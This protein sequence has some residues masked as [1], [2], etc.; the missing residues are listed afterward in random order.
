MNDVCDFCNDEGAVSR[1]G[2][3][4]PF[5]SREC[6]CCC[7]MGTP[8][9]LKRLNDRDDLR[10]T[11]YNAD[12]CQFNVLEQI[13]REK[14]REE[15]LPTA[16]VNGGHSKLQLLL[17]R[18]LAQTLMSC[19]MVGVRLTE[20]EICTERDYRVAA[21]VIQWLGTNIGQ[22]FINECMDEYRR[23]VGKEDT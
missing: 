16:G 17:S 10:T 23:R 9:K 5:E 12:R 15:T 8:E 6:E 11:G 1:P 19:S 21:T 22:C 7:K 13:F 18:R 3:G 2:Q 4:K 14:W 20:E